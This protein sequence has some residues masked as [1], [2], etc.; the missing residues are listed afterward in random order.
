MV[1]AQMLTAQKRI[2]A[3]VF[4]AATEV[5]GRILK[6]GRL[7]GLHKATEDLTGAKRN[8]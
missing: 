2:M 4:L 1:G 3:V 7:A 8:K 6:K 5:S